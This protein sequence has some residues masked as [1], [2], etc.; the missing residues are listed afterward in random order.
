MSQ[1]LRKI[2]QINIDGAQLGAQVE[3][4]FYIVEPRLE[5]RFYIAEPRFFTREPRF[6]IVLR[7]D[8]SHLSH[9][10]LHPSRFSKCQTKSTV[11]NPHRKQWKIEAP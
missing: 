10:R 3:P 9:P 2:A 5:P 6:S 8:F 1:N 4:R 11:K 7:V